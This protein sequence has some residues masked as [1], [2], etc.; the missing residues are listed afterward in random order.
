[1]KHVEW[2]AWQI[3]TV[4][5][6]LC[7]LIAVFTLWAIVFLSHH[8]PLLYGVGIAIAL[9]FYRVLF[10]KPP[11]QRACIKAIKKR[12]KEERR[13]WQHHVFYRVS[14]RART[15]Y[16][17]LCIEQALQCCGEELSQWERALK[18]MWEV[19][20]TDDMEGW[21]ANMDA[22]SPQTLDDLDTFEEWQE[23]LSYCVC[24]SK[25][26]DLEEKF[27]YYKELYQ[28]ASPVLWQLA[29]C[30]VV[31]V[32]EEWQSGDVPYMPSVLQY[33]DQA[34][35]LLQKENIPLPHDAQVLRFLMS[36]K[37]PYNGNP[38]DGLQFSVLSV[39]KVE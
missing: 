30:L 8:I 9:F 15:A 6:L 7:I 12:E 18:E 28:H 35:Y 17:I 34:R 4:A 38:F 32:T 24:S 39:Q 10:Y 31:L 37:D 27:F 5:I 33:I 25:D 36:Q 14:K 3:K 20:S 26:V 19:T 16:L 21:M 11:Q 22:F 2:K 13:R 29:C 1:M 23:E